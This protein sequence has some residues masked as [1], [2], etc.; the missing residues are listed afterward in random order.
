MQNVDNNNP[1]LKILGIVENCAIC[2]NFNDIAI[3]FSHNFLF[4]TSYKYI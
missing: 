1:F 2:K 4:S 3:K